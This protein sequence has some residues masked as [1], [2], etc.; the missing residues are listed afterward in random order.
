MAPDYSPEA[1]ADKMTAEQRV[2]QFTITN[3]Y[4]VFE[5][6]V[7]IIAILAALMVAHYAEQLERILAGWGI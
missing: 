1:L 4:P 6:G 5:L 7:I 3:P 2:K